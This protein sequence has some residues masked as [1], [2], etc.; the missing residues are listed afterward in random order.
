[1][2]EKKCNDRI[3]TWYNKRAVFRTVCMK[4]HNRNI[5]QKLTRMF[6]YN[7]HTVQWYNKGSSM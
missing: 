4:M 7:I 1:M 6:L 5:I 3:I 2:Y